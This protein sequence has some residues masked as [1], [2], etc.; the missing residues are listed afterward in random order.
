MPRK[1]KNAGDF[2][3]AFWAG[4]LAT[5]QPSGAMGDTNGVDTPLH[6]LHRIR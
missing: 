1:G 4:H 2:G 3:L 5:E 6:D